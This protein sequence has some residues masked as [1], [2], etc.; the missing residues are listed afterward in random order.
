MQWVQRLALRKSLQCCSPVLSY[1]SLSA[2]HS[3]PSAASSPLI[4]FVLQCLKL[5][6]NMLVPHTHYCPTICS[7]PLFPFHSHFHHPAHSDNTVI[8]GKMMNALRSRLYAWMVTD[9]RFRAVAMAAVLLQSLSV[10]QSV[11]RICTP[12]LLY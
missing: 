6:G 12:F 8:V 10:F 7:L 5:S 11:F 9:V 3:H 2:S 1:L 4:S